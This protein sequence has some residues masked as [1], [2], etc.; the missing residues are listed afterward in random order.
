M[1]QYKLGTTGWC[2]PSGNQ[3]LME[4]SKWLGLDALQLEIGNYE[5]GLSLCQKP[6]QDLL[7]ADSKR[8]GIQLL[9]LALNSLC[10]YG[11]VED[12]DSTNGIIAKE[13][14]EKGIQIASDMQL[15]G[16][17]IPSFFASEIKNEK[18]YANTVVFLKYACE[19]A[20]PLGLSVYTENILDVKEQNKLFEDVGSDCLLL[21]FDSQNYT[22]FN[23]T[24]AVEVLKAHYN[25]L[26]TCIHLK[27][28]GAM[29]SMLLGE[30][31]S[32]FAEI[33]QVLRENAYEG[34]I[35]IENNYSEKPLSLDNPDYFE[36]LRK[37][38]ATVKTHMGN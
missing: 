31:Q 13:I 21:L 11:I 19:L 1:T 20:T 27:D 38:I 32:P 26:G 33:M 5:K 23:K 17:T 15:G 2:I 25:R 28:G 3:Y 4:L 10:E 34:S 16:V 37:D 14:I 29:G 8:L 6:V 7:L 9:P 24:C 18:D 35:I 12:F 30:G 22:V 36:N